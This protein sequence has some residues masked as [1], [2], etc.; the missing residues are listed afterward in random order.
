MAGLQDI[1][2][3]APLSI[4]NNVTGHPILAAASEASMPA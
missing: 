3:I 2:P 4:V 1:L